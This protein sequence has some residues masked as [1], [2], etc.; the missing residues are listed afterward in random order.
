MFTSP[1]GISVV[2]KAWYGD[3]EKGCP[4]LSGE[5]QEAGRV[6]ELEQSQVRPQLQEEQRGVGGVGGRLAL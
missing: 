6:K 5:N 4:C 2:R 3:W 1:Y